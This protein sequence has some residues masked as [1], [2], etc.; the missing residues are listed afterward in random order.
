MRGDHA[1]PRAI[2]GSRAYFKCGCQR[3]PRFDSYNV[4]RYTKKTL[5]VELQ[6]HWPGQRFGSNRINE[7]LQHHATLARRTIEMVLCF[8][9]SVE[10]NTVC[11]SQLLSQAAG[12]SRYSTLV[13]YKSKLHWALGSS[14]VLVAW[15]PLLVACLFGVLN[16]LGRFFC[17][18]VVF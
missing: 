6:R 7:A 17:D 1:S 4:C 10:N 16:I 12:I 18:G 11:F 14:C 2:E 5:M 13:T 9:C 3:N 15:P 8:G